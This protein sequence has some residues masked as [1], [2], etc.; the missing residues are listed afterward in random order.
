MSYL[1]DTHILLW[2]IKGDEQGFK[3]QDICGLAEN[4]P[5]VNT[6]VIYFFYFN[7]MV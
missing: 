1:I 4:P 3:R 5:D 2:F 6:M 7:L